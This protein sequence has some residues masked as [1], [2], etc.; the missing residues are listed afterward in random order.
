M[1]NLEHG[2][3]LQNFV[4]GNKIKQPDWKFIIDWEKHFITV[5]KFSKYNRYKF[6]VV[7]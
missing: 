5:F 4:K 7:I 3:N 6:N 2:H 1:L